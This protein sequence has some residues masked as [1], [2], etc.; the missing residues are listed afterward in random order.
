MEKLSVSRIHTYNR[1]EHLIQLEEK[2]STDHSA[3][4]KEYELIV[5]VRDAHSGIKALE[6]GADTLYFMGDYR[7]QHTIKQL[8]ELT[9]VC[10]AKG[11]T[12]FYMLPQITRNEDVRTI[13]GLLKAAKLRCPNLGLVISNLAHI[14][15]AKRLD[16]SELRGNFTLNITNSFGALFLQKNNVKGLCTSPELNISQIKNL[17]RDTDISMEAVVY[18]YLPAM[19]TE[20]CPSSEVTSCSRCIEGCGRKYALVDEKNKM[21]KLVQMGK[22]KN[23]I[24]NSDILCVYDNLATIGESGIARFRLDFYDEEEAVVFDVTKAFK[25]KLINIRSNTLSTAIEQIK[26]KGYTKGHYFRGIE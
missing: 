6:A 19:I 4:M 9:E 20:Y 5:A 17:R 24:L 16:I 15:L 3:A 26:E 14:E 12:L 11:S 25:D 13:E 7:Y 8:E 23:I 21:F 22:G 18:G 1:T 10:S 2:L